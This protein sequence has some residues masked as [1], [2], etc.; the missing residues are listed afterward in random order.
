MRIGTTLV[1]LLAL[2]SVQAEGAYEIAKAPL[3]TEWGA[4]MEPDTAWREYPRPQMVRGKWTC[5]NGLW[6]YAI[7]SNVEQRA[8]EIAKG[9]ILVPFAFEAPLSGVGRL[10]E[11]HEKMIYT[12]QIEVHPKAGRRTLLNFEAVDWR[13]SVFVNGV[14]AMDAPHEGGNLPFSVDITPFVRDGMNELKVVIWDPTHTFIN[15]GGKQDEKTHGCFYTRVSGIWQTVWM[16]EVPE[17]HIK[18]YKVFTDIETGSV[19]FEF[20]K[21][22]TGEVEVSHD[23]PKDFVCWT[24]DNPKLYNFTAKFG[25]DEIRGYFAMRKIDKAKDAKGHWR[26]RL[27]NEFIF[28]MGTLD[29][30]WWPD[31][32]LTPPSVAACE[33]DIRTLKDCGFNMMRKHI[34]VEPRIYYY[35]CDRMG[36][37]IF[38]DAPSPAGERNIFD[39]M[40]SLQR[41]GM[42]RREWKEEVDHLMNH[43]SIVM[44]IPFN[45]GWGQPDREYTDDT[46]RWTK[47][48][49]RT[50]LV[51]GPSGWFD[52]EGGEFVRVKP[53]KHIR[54]VGDWESDDPS[55][56][57]VDQ[58]NYPGPGQCKNHR[59]RISI[60][61]EFGG[62]GLKVA[63][64]LW[65]EKDVW[66]YAGTGAVASQEANQGHY[67]ELIDG[68]IPLVAD[69]LAGTVYTQTTDV[70]IEI[71]GL[72][73]YDRKVLKFD[74]SVLRI[75]HKKVFDAARR[76]D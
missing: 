35:L 49:D 68:L 17:K 24:P 52:F 36:M 27:N 72:M 44:W 12:R 15:A 62:L 18:G 1:V 11:P 14:E 63:G 39:Q 22:G 61:G 43:P 41:Y 53:W 21:V 51:G 25:E 19:R 73:T 13:A 50:R 10:V 46:L 75:A 32:L 55:C 58:H 23:M 2:V 54:D 20:D 4:A 45:E 38:Q 60:L 71:N 64:H 29:Q 59:N 3:L 33:H 28:P 30:G 65:S 47:R 34:K 57:T 69:G 70:E 5:L 6:D 7:T 40:K 26:F 56:D 74:P 37:M 8:V 67:L 76:G 48:Y 9:Q 16:E 66:G 31:G 42:F